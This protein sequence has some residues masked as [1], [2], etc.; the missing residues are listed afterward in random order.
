MIKILHICEL[1]NNLLYGLCQ[2]KIISKFRIYLRTGETPYVYLVSVAN[3]ETNH[4][5]QC[6][7]IELYAEC[8]IEFISEEEIRND[9]FY[10]LIFKE[11]KTLI[12]DSGRRRYQSLFG[13]KSVKQSIPVVS[14]YSYKGGMGRTTTMVAYAMHLSMNLGKKVVLIDCDIE[15]PGI[16]NFFLKNPAEE[17]QRNGLI[18]YLLDKECGLSSVSDINDYFW[19]ADSTFSGNGKIYVMPAGNLSSELIVDSK[20]QTHQSNYIEGISRIDI[21]NAEYSTQ[22]MNNLINDIKVSLDPDVILIDSKTGLC[23][24]MGITTCC[25]SDF[26]VGFFRSDVQSKP[27]LEFFVNTMIKNK[28]VETVLVNSI[29]PSSRSRSN[30]LHKTFTKLVHD[31]EDRQSC[32]IDVD[33]PIYPVSRN[34]DFEVLGST[35]EE[36][37][38]FI[39][40]IQEQNYPDY[41]NLFEGLTN[42]IFKRKDK[43]EKL[44][45]EHKN[46][47][48]TIAAGRLSNVDLY[49]ENVD[50]EH[51]IDNDV[52]FFRSCMNDLFNFDKSII[53]GSKGTGKSYIY[54]TLSSK[55]GL[56]FLQQKSGRKDNFKF[57]Y[58]IDRQKRIFRVNKID[59]NLSSIEKYRFW[60]I[61]TWSV[62][63]TELQDMYPDFLVSEGLSVN[64]I[65]DDIAYKRVIEDS[66]KS[67]EYCLKVENE[68][69]RL[70]DYLKNKEAKEYVTIIYDQLDE[71][72]TPENW[73]NWIPELINYWRIRRFSRISGKIFLR[74]DLFKS[75]VGLTN[76]KD[77]E[78]QAIDIEWKKEEIYSYFFRL[79][80]NQTSKDRI[81]EIMRLYD[82]YSQ[83]FIKLCEISLFNPDRYV[84]DMRVLKPLMITFFG[85]YV[86]P[87]N[88]SRMG[89]SYDWFFKNLKNAD[90]TISLRPFI[91]LMKEAIK[92]WKEDKYKNQETLS[93]ILYQRYYIDTNVRKS[94]ASN[95]CEDLVRGAIGNEPIQYLFSFYDKETS[96]RYKK[97][98]LRQ[99][100]F[101]EMLSKVIIKY[102]EKESMKDM[103]I[104]ALA[105][106]LITNGIVKRE[107]YGR[108]NIYVFSFLYKYRLGLKGS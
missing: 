14:F 31:I 61:Y 19:Q 77:I 70:D 103:S 76:V 58:A 3:D 100:L 40:V 4:S 37:T 93:P 87:E 25:I 18:E 24:I 33:F 97:I 79:I 96:S 17:N 12:F 23:D 54:K 73:N 86:D 62:L 81:L 50:I 29:L 16:T 88:T 98:S 15:A 48:L 84:L 60:L 34:A 38:D 7:I 6:K 43:A 89:F 83:D 74:S 30:E 51:D 101:E 10:K 63:F 91:D 99:A 46:E 57:V 42:V 20:F 1:I 32:N 80:L 35:S 45:G 5:V 72:V 44:I 104:E 59:N 68:F 69:K 8:Q 26:C 49:A 105:N 92:I 56:E 13:K 71:V 66:I 2:E 9:S 39:S 53:L 107:N 108:G 106:I 11:R 55:R 47:I 27:G 78:N 28:K 22:I 65:E 95:Y 64:K 52:F 85:K 21:S 94:A 90:D 36:I 75:L 82:D 41:K 67:E 102:Q